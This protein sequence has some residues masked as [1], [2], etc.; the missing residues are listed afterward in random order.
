MNSS[1]VSSFGKTFLKGSALALVAGF[2]LVRLA[3]A[4]EGKKVDFI[5]DVQP[6]FKASC[7]KCHG[8]DPKKPK[9]KAAGGFRLDDKTAALKGGKYG[10]DIVPGKSKDSRLFQ[11]L[12]GPV[13]VTVDDK[14]KDVPPMPKVKKGEKWKPLTDDQIATIKQWIDQGADWPDAK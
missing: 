4:D 9:K 5:K 12:S 6:I 14:D 2:G 10:A 1:R 11:L 7:V 8:V 13:T 3:A